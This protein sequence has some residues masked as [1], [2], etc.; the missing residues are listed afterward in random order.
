[1]LGSAL[2]GSQSSS[3]QLKNTETGRER[4]YKAMKVFLCME[5]IPLPNLSL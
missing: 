2:Y 5:H 3:E 4:L 1:M